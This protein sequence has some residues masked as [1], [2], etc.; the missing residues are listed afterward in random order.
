MPEEG[1]TD[2]FDHIKGLMGEFVFERSN[3][4]DPTA[5]PT[6]KK[7][8]VGTTKYSVISSEIDSLIKSVW[9][10]NDDADFNCQQWVEYAPRTL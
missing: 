10:M 2:S 5:S 1:P 6:F 8:Q 9:V 3:E 7:V 4:F